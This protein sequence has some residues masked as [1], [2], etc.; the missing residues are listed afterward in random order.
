LRPRSRTA[1]GSPPWQALLLLGVLG[2]CSAPHTPLLGYSTDSE[3]SPAGV[4]VDGRL[5]VAPV[6][7]CL[8]V[9]ATG[10]PPIAL[11]WPPGYTVTFEPIQVFDQSGMVIATEGVDL[12]FGGSIIRRPNL[13]CGTEST[14]LVIG[15]AKTHFAN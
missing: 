2:A 6:A 5:E 15:V 10:Y 9:K 13:S 12:S 8:A 14:L 3:A 7:P 4:V 1:F 11:A